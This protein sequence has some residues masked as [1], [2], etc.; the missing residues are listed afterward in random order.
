MNSAIATRKQVD[1]NGKL[2]NNECSHKER[3]ESCD[4]TAD[5]VGVERADCG[6]VAG[7][8]ERNHQVQHEHH[9]AAH[10]VVV[11]FTSSWIFQR[12]KVEIFDLLLSAVDDKFHFDPAEDVRVE[13]NQEKWLV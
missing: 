8:E 9:H 6:H 13:G 7:A 11:D 2:K 1:W 3:R 5:P 10:V 12:L 4:E